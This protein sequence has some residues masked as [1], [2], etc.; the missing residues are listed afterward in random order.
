[1]QFSA[2]FLE[3]PK[4]RML[5]QR[6]S[7][8]PAVN[9]LTE[10]EREWAD[11]KDRIELPR[12]GSVAVGIGQADFTTRRLV[13]KIDFQVTAVNCLTACCPEAGKLP[14][15]YLSD[16]EAI[17]VAMVTLRPY[18]LEDLRLVHI[19]NTL[20]LDNLMVSEG[21]L[22]DLQGKSHVAIEKK[23]LRLEFDGSGNLLSPFATI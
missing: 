8:L 10:M 1:M 15:A 5:H 13:D 12:K 11:L 17:A 2:Q 9:V 6:F 14:L 3:L 18:S 23:S 21:C 4:M 20:D 16:R 22:S 7:V 19:K